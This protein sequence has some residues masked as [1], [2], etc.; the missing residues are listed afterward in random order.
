MLDPLFSS[1]IADTGT[2]TVYLHLA[3]LA[4]ARYP[5]ATLHV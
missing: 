2:G 4:Y 1:G 5:T 3:D